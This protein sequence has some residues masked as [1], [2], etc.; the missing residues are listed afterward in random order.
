MKPPIRRA[1]LLRRS[2]GAVLPLLL[3]LLLGA[4]A[5]LAAESW[6]LAD[7]AGH[8]LNA[9]VFEQPFPEYPSGQRLRL[10]ALEPGL[11][12]DHHEELVL[13][14]SSGQEWSLPNHSEEL[15]Q[16][17]APIPAG[18]AQFDLDA[19]MPRPSEALPLR[20]SVT[21]DSGVLGFD[22]TPD[23]AMVLHSLASATRGGDQA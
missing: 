20:L 18:S 13:S 8:R 23:Q 3:V 5:A 22:L 16:K 7:G 2:L 10:N 15:V 6:S 9:R 17:A 21:S 19:L 12:L 4:S 11:G 14:D 1:G